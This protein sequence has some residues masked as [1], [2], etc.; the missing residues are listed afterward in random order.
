MQFSQDSLCETEHKHASIHATIP[1]YTLPSKAIILLA[2]D[3]IDN[4]PTEK[5][6][7]TRNFFGN[8]PFRCALR[9]RDLEMALASCSEHLQEL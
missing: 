7:E 9:S 3:I 4:R 8:F 5:G 1:S 6:L 2:S